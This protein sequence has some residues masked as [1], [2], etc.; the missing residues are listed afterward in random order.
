MSH[1]NEQAPD[2]KI[3]TSY[4]HSYNDKA[5]LTSGVCTQNRYVWSI[6]EKAAWAHVAA[7][8]HD[9]LTVHDVLLALI[10]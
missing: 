10:Q 1:M 5:A 6:P 2:Y 4:L 8:G 7:P 9:V 3:A